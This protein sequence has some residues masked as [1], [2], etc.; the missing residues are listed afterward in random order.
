M[1]ADRDTPIFCLRCAAQLTPGKGNF[2]VVRILA[3]ADPYPPRFEEEDLQLD[4]E[5]EVDALLGEMQGMSEE[6]L[7][8]Q[9]FRRLTIHLCST[10]YTDWIEDPAG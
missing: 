8:D 3:V 2:Y 4:I 1:D 6:E 10:C 9:V 7:T 5:S